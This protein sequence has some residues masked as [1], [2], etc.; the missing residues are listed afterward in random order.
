M[1]RRLLIAS[2]ILTATAAGIAVWRFRP[3][4]PPPPPSTT[5]DVYAAVARADPA[6]LADAEREQWVTEVAKTLERLPPHEFEKLVQRAMADPQWRERFDNLP[7]DQRRK[8]AGSISQEKQLDMMLRVVK[9]LK[10]A[11]P[12]LRKALIASAYKRMKSEKHREV[13]KERMVERMASTTPTRR[14]EFVRALRDLRA[15]AEEAGIRE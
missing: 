15:M 12:L 2:A 13:S 14:A 1:R 8:L 10:K 6:K 3:P 7:P 5:E 4:P 11:P 9:E